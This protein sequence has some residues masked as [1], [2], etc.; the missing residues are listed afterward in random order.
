MSL[1]GF[2]SSGTHQQLRHVRLE[3]EFFL[4]KSP[5]LHA[6]GSEAIA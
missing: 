4:E 6:Y 2:K 1:Y 5:G 3:V